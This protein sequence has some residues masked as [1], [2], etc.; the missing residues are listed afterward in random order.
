MVAYPIIYLRGYAG[1][2][3]GVEQTVD[4]PFYGFNTG[5]TH[6]RVGAQGAPQFFAFE[7]PVLRLMTDHGYRDAYGGGLQPADG[8]A[9]RAAPERSI[10]IHRYYDVTSKTFERARSDVRRLEIEDAAASLAALIASVKAATGAAKVVLVGHSTGGLIIR[11]LLQKGYPEKDVDPTEH[12]DRVFTYGTPHGGIHFDV[13][14]GGVMEWVRD[15]I[16]WNNSDDFG[17]DRMYEYLTPGVVP[18]T[19][20]EPGFDARELGE[21][22]PP[23]RFFCL[24]GSNARDYGMP[25]HAVGPQSDGLVQI[26]SAYVRGAPRAYVHRSHSGRYGLVNSEEGY[27]N[28]RRFLFGDVRVDLLLDRLDRIAEK[29]GD[30]DSYHHA[31]AQVALRGLPVLL[32]DQQLAHHCP[33]PLEWRK[34]HEGEPIFLFS[35]FM[36]PSLSPEDDRTARYALRLTVFEMR[37]HE[38]FLMFRDHLEQIPLWTDNLVVDLPSDAERTYAGAL[39]LA[40]GAARPG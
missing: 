22:F 10:W 3:G 14:G 36:I 39:R 19:G 23:E 40:L 18:G 26:T 38:G 6:V 9:G 34:G 37:R 11:S 8:G 28:L 7:S 21:H 24:V 33:I 17:P 5:S 20:A 35:L 27:Q 13:P 25:Q 32:H 2:Q 29:V 30:E 16:G 1:N 12:V 4:D 31:E 15:Q